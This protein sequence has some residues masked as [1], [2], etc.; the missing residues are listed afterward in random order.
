MGTRRE[1][2]KLGQGSWRILGSLLP[3][4]PKVKEL[5]GIVALAQKPVPVSSRIARLR[6]DMDLSKEP[7]GQKTLDRSSR[8]RLGPHQYPAFLF[9]R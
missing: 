8:Y 9:N 6:R 4:D 7:V 5:Q 3:A 2:I 1:R